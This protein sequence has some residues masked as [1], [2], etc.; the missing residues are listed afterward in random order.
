M[1]NGGDAAAVDAAYACDMHLARGQD[2]QFCSRRTRPC[3][4]LPPPTFLILI[5]RVIFSL[6]DLT[7]LRMRKS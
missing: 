7:M 6:F 5:A 2:E 4:S 3:L 1:V